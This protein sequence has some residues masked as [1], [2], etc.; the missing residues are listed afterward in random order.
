MDG[1]NV[2]T[3]RFETVVNHIH[4]RTI[5]EMEGEMWASGLVIRA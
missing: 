3:L 1:T 5:A 4:L 2:H